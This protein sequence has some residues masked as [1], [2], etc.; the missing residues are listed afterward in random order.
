M[1][2]RLKQRW[3]R[4]VAVQPCP[5]NL[6]PPRTKSLPKPPHLPSTDDYS[7]DCLSRDA[8]GWR[9]TQTAHVPPRSNVQIEGLA[10]PNVNGAS[11]VQKTAGRERTLIGQSRSNAGLGKGMGELAI[12]RPAPNPAPLYAAKR[13]TAT[14]K[15]PAEAAP[16]G[17]TADHATRQTAPQ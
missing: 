8:S 5:E 14:D 9:Q 13:E 6:K 11:K 1:P 3:L 12:Q 2:A 7:G 16:L 10:A 17:G 15:K 4:R